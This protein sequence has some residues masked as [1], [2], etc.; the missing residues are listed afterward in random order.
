MAGQ[1]DQVSTVA[2]LAEAECPLY[3]GYMFTPVKDLLGYDFTDISSS[4][5]DISSLAVASYRSFNACLA[6]PQCQSFNVFK[7]RSTGKTSSILKYWAPR[8]DKLAALPS[9]FPGQECAGIYT[10]APGNVLF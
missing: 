8:P 3:D 4:V 9:T 1:S 10:K 6:T 7:S 2:M 5:K